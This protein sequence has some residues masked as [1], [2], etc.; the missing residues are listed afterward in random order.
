MATIE[1]TSY[2]FRYPDLE[3]IINDEKYDLFKKEMI[4]NNY[5]N[6][7]YKPQSFFKKYRFHFL[8]YI[9]IILFAI[10]A[11][12]I[13]KFHDLSIALMVLGN[14]HAIFT[15]PS[16][17]SYIKFLRK[18]RRY[19]KRLIFRIKNSSNYSEFLTLFNID[20]KEFSFFNLSDS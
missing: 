14:F 6:P 11:D 20:I 3:S 18:R 19:Y 1:Y 7:F 17:Q 10:Y 16:M 4:N 15:I 2:K 12:S 5:F 13:D 8:A 9:L